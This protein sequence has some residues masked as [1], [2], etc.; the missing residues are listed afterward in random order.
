MT[1]KKTTIE[2]TKETSQTQALNLIEQR[3]FISLTFLLW[4]INLGVL[5][6]KMAMIISRGHR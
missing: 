1:V 4:K 3:N 2:L 6:M 5:K